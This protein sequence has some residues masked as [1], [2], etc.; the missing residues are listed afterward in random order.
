MSLN[1]S[2]KKFAFKSLEQIK[3]KRSDD[4]QRNYIITFTIKFG[5]PVI[6]SNFQLT[7]EIEETPIFEFAKIEGN[8]LGDFVDY[9]EFLDTNLDQT[10]NKGNKEIQHF[11]GAGVGEIVN[12]SF[13]IDGG[14]YRSVK[15]TCESYAY[16]SNYFI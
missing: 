15:E 8:L 4:P 13:S 6:I 5:Y 14:Y 10:K 3:F 16:E 1:H 11:S 7:R 2:L 12:I 9:E